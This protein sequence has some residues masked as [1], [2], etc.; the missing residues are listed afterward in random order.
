VAYA[1]KKK[2]NIPYI[3][4]VRGSDIYTFFKYMPHLRAFGNKIMMEAERVI[5]INHSYVEIFRKKYL[6]NFN[7]AIFDNISVVPNAIEDRW[8]SVLTEEKKNLEKPIRLLY[9]GRIVKLKK[10]D[11]VIK[12]LKKL[13]GKGQKKYLLEVVG[14]GEFMKTAKKISDEHVI[15]HGKISDFTTL[16]TIYTRCHIFVMP[17]VKETFGLVYIEALSQGLPLVFCKG[18]GVDGFFEKRA[19]GL[20]VRPNSIEDVVK[21]IEEIE[22]NYMQLTKT[23]RIESLRFN[24]DECTSK[25]V[26]IYKEALH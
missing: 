10:L 15:F 20:A 4:S 5:F 14:E 6:S 17:S 19:V 13:N 22:K 23:A 9:V 24:W 25:F 18:Q 7:R 12:A 26:E 16:H 2:Y 11:V 21:A 1:L 3:A 8:F